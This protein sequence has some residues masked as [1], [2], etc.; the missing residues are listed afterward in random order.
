M[1]PTRFR[2]LL[3]IGLLAGPLRAH[4]QVTRIDSL[5]ADSAAQRLSAVG[6]SASSSAG[7][8]GGAAAIV[9]KPGELRS[10]PAPL[11]DQVLRE[12]PFVLVRQ[13]SR[14]EM[15]ISVRGSDSRQASV[16]LDGVPLSLGWDHSTDPSVLPATG[17]E[18]IE[19]VRGLGSLLKGPNT[20]GGTIE[21]THDAFGQP[22]GGR[23]WAGLGV[24]QFGS[25]VTTLGYGG[26]LA[27]FGG[28]ALSLRA[29]AA[30]RQRDG[31]ALPDEASDP[32]A[33]DGLR[34]GTDM[35]QFDGFAS[36]R[37]NNRKGA[38]LGFM[39]SGFDAERGVPPEENITAPR[40]W[41][42]PYVRRQVATFFA[43]T[44]VPIA[45]APIQTEH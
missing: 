12:S 38:S 2:V 22:A 10:S 28:G 42:Y 30:H 9:V 21:I 8:I 37:W 27:E 45:T 44:F 33:Q 35:K 17:T 13:N 4:A 29:G 1:A 18:R 32:T 20:L 25:T 15:E 34:T 11:L 31:V 7:T 19:I 5:R 24:D 43:G 41:R 26:R 3:T 23:A 39:Y 36:V 16:I 40:L 6:V 14:G